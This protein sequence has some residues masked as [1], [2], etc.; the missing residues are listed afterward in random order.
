M[1]LYRNFKCVVFSVI[2]FFAMSD[3]AFPAEMTHQKS[4]VPKMLQLKGKIEKGDAQKLFEQI[5]R[6]P[7]AMILMLSSEGGDLSEAIKIGELVSEVYMTVF[8]MDKCYSA[9]AFIALAAPSRMFLGDIG[10]HRPYF[11][12]SYFSSLS[13]TR[14]E[15][16]YAGLEQKA[17]AFLVENYVPTDMIDKMFNTSSEDVLLIDSVEAERIFG[18][19]KPSFHEWLIAKCGPEEQWNRCE[20]TT[21]YRI[22]EQA[23][24]EIGV[25]VATRQREDYYWDA[26]DPLM[27]FMEE[28]ITRDGVIELAKLRENFPQYSDL[29]GKEIVNQLYDRYGSAAVPREKFEKKF[30]GL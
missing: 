1:D 4:D 14:A 7:G 13:P 29:S 15:E 18:R 11:D 20:V 27:D 30:K 5:V 16:R 23:A 25:A 28:S 17:R 12:R 9:C 8:V 3:S 21:M 19:F 6:N 10:L 2:V 24:F 26:H 22:H